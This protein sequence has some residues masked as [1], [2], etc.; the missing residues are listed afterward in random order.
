MS[1]TVDLL[2]AIRAHLTAF[3]LP[4]LY[5]VNV[6]AASGEPGVSAHLAAHHPPQIA[7][8]LLAW[9]DTLTSATAEAWRV[10]SGDSIH[11][12]VIGR[13]PSDVT[14]RVYGGV[15]LTPHGIGADLTPDGSATVSLTVLRHLATPGEV[16]L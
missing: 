11:L 9:A 7:T 10:P 5:S 16:T 13:L 6:V 15:P 3:E 4:Q 14:I 1:T 8:G 2:D 12:S